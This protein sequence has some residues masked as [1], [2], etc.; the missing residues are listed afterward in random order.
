MSLDVLRS[1]YFA[2]IHSIV[3]YGIIF[4][5]ISS[6]SEETFKLEERL[7]RLIMN[8]NKNA[9]CRKPFGELNILQVPSLYILSLLLFTTRNKEQFLTH[10]QIHRVTTRQS[11]N[12][13]VP[14][15]NMTIYQKV[16]YY[17]GIKIY[18]HYQKLLNTYRVIKI[19]LN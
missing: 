16:V 11:F 9:S 19:N 15:A 10:S 3:S 4:W 18:S 7:I 2:Y 5:G 8:L 17:Q 13:Y 1:T 14:S 12:L 6:Y